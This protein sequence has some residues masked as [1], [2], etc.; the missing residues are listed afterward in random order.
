VAV[1]VVLHQ[2]LQMLVLLVVLVDLVVVVLLMDP[3]YL[4]QQLLHQLH[5]QQLQRLILEVRVSKVLVDKAHQLVVIHMLLPVA[6]ALVVLVVMDQPVEDPHIL[7]LLVVLVYN[8]LQHSM[9]QHQL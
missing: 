4:D 8:L 5:P 1:V 3:E 6:A 7:V 9:I 2:D